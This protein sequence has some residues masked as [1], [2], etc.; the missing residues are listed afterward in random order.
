MRIER[1]GRPDGPLNLARAHLIL[2]R[3][4]L[5]SEWNWAA[6]EQE[7]E[8]HLELNP[9]SALGH[10]FYSWVLLLT[11]RIDEALEELKRTIELE[12]LSHTYT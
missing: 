7:L 4:D 3:V 8:R 10:G 11:G 1:L 5:Q 12:P 2:A 9:N 6:A